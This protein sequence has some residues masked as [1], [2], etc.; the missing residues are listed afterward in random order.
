[1]VGGVAL[2]T[3]GVQGCVVGGGHERGRARRRASP[4][5]SYCAYILHVHTHGGADGPV[6]LCVLCDD[7]RFTKA[8]KQASGWTAGARTNDATTTAAA[9]DQAQLI[10]W[11]RARARARAEARWIAE[12]VACRG[13][14][15]ASG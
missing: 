3:G 11:G 12:K 8:G 15:Q 6:V 9:A 1:M 7:D 10:A 4:P 13:D 14:E 5:S 2:E